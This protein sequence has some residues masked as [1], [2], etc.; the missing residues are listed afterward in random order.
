MGQPNE[1]QRVAKETAMEVVGG[2]SSAKR[3]A[4]QNQL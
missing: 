1:D 2:R 4:M 3:P